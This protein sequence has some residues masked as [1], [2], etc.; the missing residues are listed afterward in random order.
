MQKFK[1]SCLD[2]EDDYF[3]QQNSPKFLDS[4]KYN[5]ILVFFKSN[6]ILLKRIIYLFYRDTSLRLFFKNSHKN[7]FFLYLIILSQIIFN[8]FTIK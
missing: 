3:M 8:K 7:L 5:N 6:N 1:Y 2:N 4:I